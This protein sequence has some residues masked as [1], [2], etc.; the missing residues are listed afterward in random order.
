MNHFDNERTPNIP[1]HPINHRR[2]FRYLVAR[3]ESLLNDFAA[4]SDIPVTNGSIAPHDFHALLRLCRRPAAQ[5]M[6]D[7]LDGIVYLISY[8]GQ[9]AIF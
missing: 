7:Y 6:V 1:A 8:A 2:S 3:T 9:E 5:I 4:Q